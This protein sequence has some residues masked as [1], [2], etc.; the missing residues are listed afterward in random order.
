VKTIVAVALITLGVVSGLLLLNH[1]SAPKDQEKLELRTKLE[2]QQSRAAAEAERAAA[3][4]RDLVTARIEAARKPQKAAQAPS[5]ST[6]PPAS[7][8]AM[9]KDPAMRQMMEKQQ[10]QA[11]ERRVK[12]L[13]NADMQKKL[14]R[15]SEQ[16]AHL[17]D[18]LKR[19]QQPAVELMMA[20]M[21]GELDETE[22]TARS[23]QAKA[24]RA[25]ADQEI[26]DFLGKDKY[27]YLDWFE[28]SDAERGRVRD[29]RSQFA[30]AGAPLSHE[31]EEQLTLAMF[32]ERQ[33][34]KFAI[35]YHDP[36]SFDYSRL[37]DYFNEANMERFF[38]EMSDLN[39][40]T[41]ARVQSILAPEQLQEFQRLQ[42]EHLE[43][44][45]ATVRMTHT[46]FPI[47]KKGAP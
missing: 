3:L 44:G 7:G 5:Q 9:L 32:D 33:K 42:S 41:L 2:E 11:L 13:V 35:D 18:L 28:R 27:D 1:R 16:S 37:D 38:S 21:S 40:K 8:T 22:A 34:F 23:T 19:K 45:K 14:G 17:R 43:R 46:L 6:N 31:Q 24:A 39:E 36:S 30:D 47:R 25:A 10:L 29:F 15:D 4:E 20:L 12:Q 26:H